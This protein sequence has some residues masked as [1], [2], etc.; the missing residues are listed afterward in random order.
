MGTGALVT[1]PLIAKGTPIEEPYRLSLNEEAE[2]VGFNHIKNEKSA[3][4][5]NAI[6]HKADSRGH[7]DHGWLKTYHSFSFANYYNPDR[8]H[9]GALRVLND[10]FI[11]PGRGF[12]MHPH[13]DMEI[14]TIPLDGDLAHKDNMG[15]SS[16]IK[17][18]DVQVMSAGTGVRHSE[19]NS[20]NDKE[21]KLLQ[22][23]VFPNKKNVKPRY[24]QMTLS[25]QERKNK[26]QQILSPNADDAGVWIH[27]R[28]WFHLADFDAGRKE[29]YAIKHANNGAYVFLLDGKAKVAGVELSA[30]DAIGVWDVSNV[31]FEIT[32]K[33]SL[34]VMDIPMK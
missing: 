24:D 6:L 32:E 14:I 9:F 23:W 19:F 20:N 33:T 8:M 18:G 12:G 17:N 10:D 13:K 1:T 29:R 7:A 31:D 25:V 28:A 34:L 26:F 4:M 15:N 21:V 16:I 3:I 2:I 5:K 27:Q 30:R 11:A 22:I